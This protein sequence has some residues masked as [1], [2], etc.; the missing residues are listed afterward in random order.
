METGPNGPRVSARATR[1]RPARLRRCRTRSAPLREAVPSGG[2]VPFLGGMRRLAL[3]A[4]AVLVLATFVPLVPAD[5]WLLRVLDFPRLQLFVLALV[6]AAGLAPYLVRRPAWAA[7]NVLLALTLAAAAYQGARVLPY[8]PLWPVQ[9][10]PAAPGEPGPTL[11]LFVAN[12]LMENRDA[13]RLLAQIRRHA[14]DLVVLTEPDAWWAAQLRPLHAAY[15]Y[16]VEVPQPNTYGMIV[17]SRRPLVRPVVKRLFEPGIPSVHTAVVLG[18]RT[19]H[20]RFIHPKPPAPGEA[21]TTTDRDAEILTVG[22]EVRALGGPAV[23][24]GDLNDVAWSS[25]TRLA[26]RVSG[27]L[28]PRRGRGLYATFHADY[29]LL[30]WPLDHVFHTEHFELVRLER[31]G[32]NGSDHFPILVAL[33]LTPNAPAEQAPPAPEPDDAADARGQIRDARDE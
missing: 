9:V 6:G 10:S 28:D 26:Q 3:F 5:W 17:L 8:T 23:V 4:A 20:L 30:R 32:P 15:P 12:V 29:P 13:T 14:P 16:R 24:A 7:P 25:T 33:R 18:G 2:S 21:R 22:R 11:R 27:L 1:A 19:V 31:L